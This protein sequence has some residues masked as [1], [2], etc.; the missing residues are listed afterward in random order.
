MTIQT[1]AKLGNYCTVS[2]T[3]NLSELVLCVLE[4]KLTPIIGFN[5]QI[6]VKVNITYSY[7]TNISHFWTSHKI[8][9]GPVGQSPSEVKVSSTMEFMLRSDSVQTKSPFFEV[10]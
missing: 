10:S 9:N 5:H 8:K 7:E 4:V 2:N 1:C 3:V 6:K